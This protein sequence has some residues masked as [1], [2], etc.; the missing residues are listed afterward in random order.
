MSPSIMLKVWIIESN[1]ELKA[2]CGKRA[3]HEKTE[4]KAVAIFVTVF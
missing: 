3:H 1:G 4:S 2:S